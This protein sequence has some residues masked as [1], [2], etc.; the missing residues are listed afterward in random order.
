MPIY[1]YRCEKC[2]AIAE[3]LALGKEERLPAH[4]AAVRTW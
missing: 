4:S 1:E 3:V 2:G